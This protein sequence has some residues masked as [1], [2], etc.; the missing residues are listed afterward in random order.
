MNIYL[1]SLIVSIVLFT[2][3]F[4]LAQFLKN[5]SIIDIFWGLGFV[6]IGV[7]HFI[8]NVNMYNGIVLL[9]ITL[10]GGRL[11]LHI[12]IRNKKKE[13]FRY[14]QFREQWGGFF[15]L[16]AF[17][18]IFMLQA[19]LL[20]VIS[21]PIS[22]IMSSTTE[23]VL[24]YIIGIVVWLIGYIIEVTSDEQLRAFK[25]NNKG[26]INT[27]LWKY[28]R[29]PNYFGEVVIWIGVFIISIAYGGGFWLVVS[30]FTIWA[31]FE[32]ISIPILEKK[33]DSREEYQIY[34]KSTNKLVLMRRKHDLRH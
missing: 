34:K 6:T 32:F 19:I 7:Y 27:G 3:V 8:T 16:K 33:Y 17:V 22:R 28:S 2:S 1:E 20:F 14:R 29:H 15:V 12:L 31:V 13:D 25:K 24:I 26:L 9:L 5:N 4:I 18:K 23:S 11:S 30:P 10:W 21:L